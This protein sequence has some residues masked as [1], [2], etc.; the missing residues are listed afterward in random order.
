MTESLVTE[1]LADWED[2]QPTEL[3]PFA[4]TLSRDNEIVRA[5]YALLEERGKYSEVRVYFLNDKCC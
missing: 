3:R 1:W 4:E 2:L 5:L